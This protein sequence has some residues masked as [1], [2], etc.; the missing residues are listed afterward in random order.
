MF[1]VQVRFCLVFG[2]CS[3]WRMSAN[4]KVVKCNIIRISQSLMRCV[5]IA[6]KR[7]DGNRL[8]SKWIYLRPRACIAVQGRTAGRYLLATT[9]LF[10][11]ISVIPKKKSRKKNLESKKFGC[12]RRTIRDRAKVGHRFLC[13]T[14]TIYK[15]III[16]VK[17]EAIATNRGL[18]FSNPSEWMTYFIPIRPTRFTL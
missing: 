18:S 4:P 11:K 9:W 12:D 7:R 15:S 14:K 3:L 16:A 2:T 17:A 8:S 10:R 6:S 13:I 1:Q 5:R